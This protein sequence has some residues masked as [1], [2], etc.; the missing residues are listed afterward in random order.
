MNLFL[1]NVFIYFQTDFSLQIFSCSFCIFVFS[2]IPLWAQC[3][4]LTSLLVKANDA[5]FVKVND[6]SESADQ[7]PAD[8]MLHSG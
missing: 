2:L 8:Q 4:F 1:V 5:L 3:S 6:T 7:K